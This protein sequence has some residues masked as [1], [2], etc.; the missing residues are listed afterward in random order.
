M[1]GHVNNVERIKVENSFKT[2]LTRKLYSRAEQTARIFGLAQNL[3]ND[4][5]RM[6]SNGAH[7]GIRRVKTRT[8]VKDVFTSVRSTE[9]Y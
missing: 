8:Q 1:N 6:L 3:S 2:V 9:G 5:A 4:H 7:I